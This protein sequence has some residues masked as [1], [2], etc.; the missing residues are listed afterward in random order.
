M[1][2]I[3][4]KDGGFLYFGIL[5]FERLKVEF[6][7]CD[8]F[9]SFWVFEVMYLV[10]FVGLVEK[11][12]EVLGM[13]VGVIW[14]DFLLVMGI[15]LGVGIGGIGEFLLLEIVLGFLMEWWLYEDGDEMIV[16]EVDFDCM[17][18]VN[19]LGVGLIFWLLLSKY[20]GVDVVCCVLFFFLEDLFGIMVVG[21]V[22]LG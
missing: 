14:N 6:V 4:G 9:G 12:R 5:M 2:G 11:G 13:L 10:C 16:V 7:F 19:C 17:E 15:V 21:G 1:Y 8:G 20:V 22:K 18:I 3:F